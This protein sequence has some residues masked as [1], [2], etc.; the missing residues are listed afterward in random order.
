MATNYDMRQETHTHDADSGSRSVTLLGAEQATRLAELF[1][2]LS[3]PTRVRLV[4]A[5]AQAPELCVSDLS[6][7][8]RMGQSAVSHQLAYLREM[9]LV[10]MRRA[11]RR[12][13]YALD[14]DHIRRLFEQ[15]LDHVQHG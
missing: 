4:S 3:D 6:E 10:R 1:K 5:L 9:R 13:F 8:V 7:L 2:S 12:I 15:G 11:G 14:D